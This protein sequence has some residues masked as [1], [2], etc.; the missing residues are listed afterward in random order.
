MKYFVARVH[1]DT[2]TLGESSGRAE[3]QQVIGL[4]STSTGFHASSPP[5]LSP[6]VHRRQFAVNS[7]T[8]HLAISGTH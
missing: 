3:T 2:E 6:L 4:I 8:L 1:P 5:A 7:R